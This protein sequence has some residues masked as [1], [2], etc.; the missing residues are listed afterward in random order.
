MRDLFGDGCYRLGVF[1]HMAGEFVAERR[2][3]PAGSLPSL[4]EVVAGEMPG[5]QER[6]DVSFDDGPERF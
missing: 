6:E 1:R 2:E 3:E 5:G 4:V